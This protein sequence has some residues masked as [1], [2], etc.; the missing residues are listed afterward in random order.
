MVRSR[1]TRILG[2]VSLVV[3][4]VVATSV[5]YIFILSTTRSPRCVPQSFG[6]N[7][8]F[9]NGTEQPQSGEIPVPSGWTV[10]IG[11][12]TVVSDNSHSG[13]HSVLLVAR[14]DSVAELYQNW[15]VDEACVIVLEAYLYITCN[16]VSPHRDSHTRPQCSGRQATLC[17]YPLELTCQAFF[18]PN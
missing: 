15:K 1:I 11:T 5:A 13:N 6:T 10:P 18:A 4:V 2:V 3:I 14:T 17:F 9:E 7:Q 16:T 12:A 8:G